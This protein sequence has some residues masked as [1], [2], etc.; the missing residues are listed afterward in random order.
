M[1]TSIYPKLHTRLTHCTCYGS[2]EDLFGCMDEIERLWDLGQFSED[3]YKALSFEMKNS[4][5][6]MV[7]KIQKQ[8]YDIKL[9]IKNTSQQ[10]AILQTHLKQLDF[11]LTILLPTK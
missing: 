11:E 5:E 9:A 10:W 2:A 6:A 8:I 3:E 7:K 4:K 1:D